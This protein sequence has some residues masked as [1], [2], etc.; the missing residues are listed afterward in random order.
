[1][2]LRITLWLSESGRVPQLIPPSIA[3]TSS[4]AGSGSRSRTTA[5]ASVPGRT[6][7]TFARS[8]PSPTP[9]F[10]IAFTIRPP[11]RGGACAAPGLRDRLH[12][13][14]VR[15]AVEHD[16][17]HRQ[18][19]PLLDRGLDRRGEHR[20]VVLV[21]REEHVAA[22]DVGRYALEAE[23]LEAGLQIGHLDER[24]AADVD[25]S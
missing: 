1:M 4:T 15:A 9:G 5:F 11:Q 21:A 24:P 22:R 19:K 14:A 7:A 18:L 3:L 10:G 23:L 20:G 13:P 12:D 2:S 25:A 16:D 6:N 8:A 17:L